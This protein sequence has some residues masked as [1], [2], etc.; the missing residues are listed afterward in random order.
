MCRYLLALAEVEVREGDQWYLRRT[1]LQGIAG[2]ICQAVWVSIP[3]AMQP[4]ENVVPQDN[5][6]YD[7]L[8][9]RYFK[10]LTVELGA[11]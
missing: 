10:K 6:P 1:A 4:R 8:I 5:C 9:S 3:P 7:Y 11:K 2:K